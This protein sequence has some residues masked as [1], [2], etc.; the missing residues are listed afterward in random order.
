MS[1]STL[2]EMNK[3]YQILTLG[4]DLEFE[5]LDHAVEVACASYRKTLGSSPPIDFFDDPQNKLAALKDFCIRSQYYAA[6][7]LNSEM[8]KYKECYPIEVAF[9]DDFSLACLEDNLRKGT[10]R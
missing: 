1:D 4:L 9:D 10:E 3:I 6:K 5:S 8:K 2:E 7:E